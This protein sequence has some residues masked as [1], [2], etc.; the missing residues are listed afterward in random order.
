MGKSFRPLQKDVVSNIARVFDRTT[1][2]VFERFLSQ[3]FEPNR[4]HLFEV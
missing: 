4:W 3:T 2:H 1:T